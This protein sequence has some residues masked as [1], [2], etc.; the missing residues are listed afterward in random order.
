MNNP[1]E[2]PELDPQ[3]TRFIKFVQD[4]VNMAAALKAGGVTPVE[5]LKFDPH[6][7]FILAQYGQG[8]IIRKYHQ[9]EPQEPFF[10]FE[11]SLSYGTTTNPLNSDVRIE[12]VGIHRVGENE[13]QRYN[14]T[15]HYFPTG[16]GEFEESFFQSY[17]TLTDTTLKETFRLQYD[18][19][20]LHLAESGE[21]TLRADGTFD[22]AWSSSYFRWLNAAGDIEDQFYLT[23]DLAK[24]L[25]GGRTVVKSEKGLRT[26]TVVRQGNHLVFSGNDTHRDLGTVEEELRVPLSYDYQK[27]DDEVLPDELLVKPTQQPGTIDNGWRHTDVAQKAGIRWRRNHPPIAN[28]EIK[29]G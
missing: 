18:E 25:E 13:M 9:P 17:F 19:G 2:T 12:N 22:I 29:N 15:A 20:N 11:S 5:V 4:E 8:P 26:F 24:L 10:S 16:D 21:S 1:A 28:Q 14:H 3:A 6:Q 27:F 23:K 7:L